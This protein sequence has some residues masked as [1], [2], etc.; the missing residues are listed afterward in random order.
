MS[1]ATIDLAAL[2]AKCFFHQEARIIVANPIDTATLGSFEYAPLLLSCSWHP[3]FLLSSIVLFQFITF[4]AEIAS[5]VLVHDMPYVGWLIIPF[6]AAHFP[7]TLGCSLAC[8]GALMLQVA[9]RLLE[10]MGG[11]FFDESLQ[12]PRWNQHAPTDF[13][14]A[15]LALLYQIIDSS[16]GQRGSRR[17]FFLGIRQ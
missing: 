1:L 11:A 15:E 13:D 9:S 5:S 14:C 3:C 17:R 12:L 8:I 6:A 4:P 2:L 16:H 7:G 10:D